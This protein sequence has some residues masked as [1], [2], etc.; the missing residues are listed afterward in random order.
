MTVF[1][2]F[3]NILCQFPIDQRHGIVYHTIEQ[4]NNPYGICSQQQQ[5]QDQALELF[6]DGRVCQR[7]FF[8]R[9][10]TL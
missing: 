8:V 6:Y 10:R 1:K 5:D 9:L 4:S 7:T 2:Q 3:L